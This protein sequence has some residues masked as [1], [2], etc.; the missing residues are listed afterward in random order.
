MRRLHLFGRSMLGVSEWFSWTPHFLSSS[1][2]VA[3]ECHCFLGIFGVYPFD[4]PG[5]ALSLRKVFQFGSLSRV[6]FHLSCCMLLRISQPGFH[7][8]V[9]TMPCTAFNDY[10]VVVCPSRVTCIVEYPA[11]YCGRLLRFGLVVVLT[12]LL[13]CCMGSSVLL[14]VEEL[15]VGWVYAVASSTGL[16]IV[17]L[18][19]RLLEAFRYNCSKLPS[20]A[21]EVLSSECAPP[22]ATPNCKHVVTGC[23]VKAIKVCAASVSS[24][25]P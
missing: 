6:G 2:T 20:A 14:E 25:C 16:E 7:P 11:G 19:R 17:C 3:F 15:A 12:T 10:Y 8:Y 13:L 21:F 24:C 22:P 5:I 4:A 23:T 18:R 1:C 9:D